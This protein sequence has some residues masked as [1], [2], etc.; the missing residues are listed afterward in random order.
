MPNRIDRLPI[1]PPRPR[2]GHK[3]LFGRVLVIGGNPE[4]IG[5]PVLAGAS[6]FRSGAGLVQI[7]MPKSVLS[8][9]LTIEPELIGLALPASPE[10]WKSATEQA[11]AIVVGPGMGQSSAARTILRAV[12]KLPGKPVVV[13]ADALNLLAAG[14]KWPSSV[15]STCVLTPHPGE[16]K[17]LAR[18]FKRTELSQTPEDRL[19]TA[20]RAAA[21]FRQVVV[22][23]GHRTIVTDAERYYVN[24]TGD[25][26]LSKAGTGD[27]LTG[28]CATL[29]AQGFDRFDAACISVWVH[30]K[31]GEIAGQ[32]F[33]QRSAMAREILSCIGEAFDEY[34]RFYGS[35]PSSQPGT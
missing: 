29:L 16:M 35:E 24:N 11:D 4:M 13:D 12:L 30:G 18:I 34:V 9:A 25:S 32:R 20:I 6:A 28:I 22:L 5:A 2:E 8:Q 19:K 21:S 7:A 27:I 3:G 31:A 17:R 26:T 14:E 33:G 15:R 10:K 1:L 23:K